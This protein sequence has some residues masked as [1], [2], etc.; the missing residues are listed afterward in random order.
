MNLTPSTSWVQTVNNSSQF[1]PHKRSMFLF[2]KATTMETNATVPI[3]AP[4]PSR[5][6]PV[7]VG[8][9]DATPSS[10]SW[11]PQCTPFVTK[12][13]LSRRENVPPRHPVRPCCSMPPAVNATKWKTWLVLSVK[14]RCQIQY[15]NTG[16]TTCNDE[17][18]IAFRGNWSRW[19]ISFVGNWAWWRISFV[20]FMIDINAWSLFTHKIL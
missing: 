5:T 8:Q 13:V 12:V 17:P 9:T 15:I 10:G 3:A 4:A 1:R 19:R 7:K 20:L 6:L 18:S 11:T 14:V 2:I 16:L